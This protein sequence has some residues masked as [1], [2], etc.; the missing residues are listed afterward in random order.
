MIT[1]CY[2]LQTPQWGYHM[3]E[4][5]YTTLINCACDFGGISYAFDACNAC[6]WLSCG[7]EA[8]VTTLMPITNTALS[9]T[10][11]TVTYSGLD[12][13]SVY[14]FNMPVQILNTTNGSGILNGRWRVTSLGTNTITFTINPGYNPFSGADTGTSSFFPGDGYVMSYSNSCVGYN[15]KGT[16]APNVNSTDY[17]MTASFNCGFRDCVSIL[18]NVG[19]IQIFDA[20]LGGTVTP[21]QG[22]GFNNNQC[23]LEN[24]QQTGGIAGQGTL[25]VNATETIWISGNKATSTTNYSA[26]PIAFFSTYWDGSASQDDIWQIGLHSVWGRIRKARWA[27]PTAALLVY[28]LESTSYSETHQ[29][30]GA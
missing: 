6:S 15:C 13:S 7:H 24:F 11:A 30:Q 19:S 18:E 2:A 10:T 26:P 14:Y 1:D 8:G 22:F 4:M 3:F 28:S 25:A 20:Y 5:S 21:G 23:F 16:D 12:M 9:G 29:T 17:I 27:S